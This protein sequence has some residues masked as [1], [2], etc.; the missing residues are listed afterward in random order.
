MVIDI[1]IEKHG[2]FS[3]MSTTLIKTQRGKYGNGAETTSGN[4]RGSIVVVAGGTLNFQRITF[5]VA[6]Y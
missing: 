1:N 3:D 5:L 2:T 6:Y 4:A